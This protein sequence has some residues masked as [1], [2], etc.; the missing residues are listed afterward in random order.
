MDTLDEGIAIRISI[1]TIGFYFLFPYLHFCA[2]KMFALI[3]K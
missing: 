1:V 2:E 3:I